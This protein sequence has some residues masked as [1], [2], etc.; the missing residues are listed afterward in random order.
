[1]TGPNDVT[2]AGTIDV[3]EMGRISREI[4][5]LRRK[6]FGE[7]AVKAYR[8]VREDLSRLREHAIR[9]AVW[10]AIAEELY[11][12]EASAFDIMRVLREVQ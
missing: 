8:E 12:D 4:A 5:V 2:S 9:V 3:E 10:R 1:M 11:E 6:G 7:Y